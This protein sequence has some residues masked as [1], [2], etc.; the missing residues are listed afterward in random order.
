MLIISWKYARLDKLSKL[1]H[2]ANVEM[3]SDNQG[4]LACIYIGL[5]VS[6]NQGMGR[7]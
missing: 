5:L 3:V 7:N 6:D 4:I 2:V 1:K